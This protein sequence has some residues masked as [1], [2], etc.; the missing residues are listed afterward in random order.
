MVRGIITHGTATIHT[1]TT[2]LYEVG[3]R[4]VDKKHDKHKVTHYFS[5]VPRRN[6]WTK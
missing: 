6:A 1:L 4:K 3:L 5:V 2:T